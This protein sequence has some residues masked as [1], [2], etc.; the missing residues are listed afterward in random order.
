MIYASCTKYNTE[1]VF[2]FCLQNVY[3][4]FIIQYVIGYEAVVSLVRFNLK[5]IIPLN[6]LFL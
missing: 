2:D 4:K 6:R 1:Q 5:T 3:L